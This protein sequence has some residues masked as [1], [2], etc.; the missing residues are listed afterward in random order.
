VIDKRQF[1]PVPAIL[2]D[3]VIPEVHGT[4]AILFHTD[5]ER[6]VYG[7]YAK[8]SERDTAFSQLNRMHDDDIEGVLAANCHTINFDDALVRFTRE[9]L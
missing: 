6:G 3:E 1:G 4:Y 8:P 5:K 9:D 2:P 7:R